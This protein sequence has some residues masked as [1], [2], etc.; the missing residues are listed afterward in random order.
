MPRVKVLI[1][2]LWVFA[3][4]GMAQVQTNSELVKI[5]LTD[6]IHGFGRH[7]DPDI[8][9]PK[10]AIFSKDGRKVYINSLERGKTV[11]YDALTHE[12]LKT[13]SHTFESGQGDLWLTSSQFYSFTH[14]PDGRER[15]FMGKPVE[16][17]LSKDGRHLFVSYYRRT[18]DINAQDPS[19]IAVI[20]TETDE[21][22]LMIETGPLPKMVKVSND[23]KLLAVT[24]WGDN[25]VGLIDIS[26]KNPKNWR[27]LSSIA[28]DKKLNL[29]F[30]LSN[31]VNRDSNSGYL[32]RGTAFLP[33][34]SILL[35]GAMAGPLAVIDVKR[36]K[37][38]GG[39]GGLR[40]VRHLI[41]KGGRLYMTRNSAGEFVTVPVDSI[42]KAIGSEISTPA[43][44][45]VNGIERVKVGSGARTLQ[46]SPS[47][48]FAFI[49]C[50][51]ASE[52][53]A[54][55]VDAKQ[56]ITRIPA[57][58]YPVGLDISPDGSLLVSTSQGHNGIGGNAVNFF[59][60]EYAIPE[61]PLEENSGIETEAS[62]PADTLSSAKEPDALPAVANGKQ[63]A[64]TSTVPIYTIII[65]VVLL[66]IIIYAV[67]L[68]R[69]NRK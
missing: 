11:V 64:D 45:Q 7:Y 34:D 54:V 15:S 60:I 26:D 18:F 62:E 61:I 13:I 56:V 27:Y 58:S 1:L 38:L 41:A 3:I 8:Y 57:D 51:S 30:S 10:S 63:E 43:N 49:A 42:L 25:T 29:D 22:V 50:N 20:D 19:A 33:G 32:L 46:V 6:K 68:I 69:K 23:G 65:C 9:S 28:I 40:G 48:R 53:V 37:W 39:F 59:R 66:A 36:G 21:I 5:T 55:D 67:C 24:H 12:K 31:P 35:V 47:G 4:P 44:F 14:Y 17:A 2:L 52:I 16:G